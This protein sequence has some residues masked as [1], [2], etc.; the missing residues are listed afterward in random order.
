MGK[1]PLFYRCPPHIKVLS[2]AR[3]SLNV[4]L[5]VVWHVIGTG[6]ETIGQW[7]IFLSIMSKSWRCSVGF[8]FFPWIFALNVSYRWTCL[9]CEDDPRSGFHQAPTIWAWK[10]VRH[11]TA[12]YLN[13]VQLIFP[14]F[15]CKCGDIQ[16]VL[17]GFR[18]SLCGVWLQIVFRSRKTLSSYMYLQE[19]RME[20][21]T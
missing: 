9:G 2:R 8:N 13:T 21:I 18:H 14:F 6:S 11:V 17:I 12:L 3:F 7:Q 16:Y 20:F 1:S 4:F 5:R 19:E 15:S 10:F